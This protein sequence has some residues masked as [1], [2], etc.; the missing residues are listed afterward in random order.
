MINSVNINTANNGF[1][2]LNIRQ[3]CADLCIERIISNLRRLVFFQ[4]HGDKDNAEQNM[5][6]EE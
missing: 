1:Y 4:E 6:I 3:A 5:K 2:I